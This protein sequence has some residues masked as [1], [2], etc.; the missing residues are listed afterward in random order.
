MGDRKGYGN[1]EE[2]MYSLTRA[3]GI[4]LSLPSNICGWTLQYGRNC[5]IFC[6]KPRIIDVIWWIWIVPVGLDWKG[7]APNERRDGRRDDGKDKYGMDRS[8]V[9]IEHQCQKK[10]IS[11]VTVFQPCYK[12]FLAALFSVD[13][14]R[15]WRSRLSEWKLPRRKS[16]GEGMDNK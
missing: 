4:M 3:T 12:T 8:M 14:T 15:G 13:F 9:D 7:K 2:C 16:Y 10:Y 11:E 6:W 5:K 1:L